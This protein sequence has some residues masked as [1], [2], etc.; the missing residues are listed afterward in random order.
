[1]I[2]FLH[3][4]DTLRLCRYKAIPYRMCRRGSLGLYVFFVF[5]N[6]QYVFIVCQSYIEIQRIENVI[7]TTNITL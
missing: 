5:K 2:T 6:H 3:V 1:M 7:E 4:R